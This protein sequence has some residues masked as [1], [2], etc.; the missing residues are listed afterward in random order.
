M[1]GEDLGVEDASVLIDGTW[2]ALAVGT[3]PVTLTSEDP[4][5]ATTVPLPN[6]LGTGGPYYFALALPADEM[7]HVSLYRDG[8]VLYYLTRPESDYPGV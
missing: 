2:H 7:Q 8:S 6:E 5:N 1:E 3:V 4:L